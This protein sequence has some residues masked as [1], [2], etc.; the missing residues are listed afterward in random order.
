MSSVTNINPELILEAKNYVEYL[1]DNYLPEK[2]V[3][4]SKKHTIDVYN[5][6]NTIGSELSLSNK[7]IYIVEIAALF[8]DIG[9]IESNINH[10]EISTLYA[11]KFLSRKRVN[12]DIIKIVTKAIMS[13]K[14]PQNPKSLIDCIL[15]DAD[16]MYL[17]GENYCNESELLRKEWIN[18][19]KT[20]FNLE[21]FNKHSLE[22]FKSHYYHTQYG[23]AI[24]EPLKQQNFIKIKNKLI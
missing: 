18:M 14:M 13:T 8:H 23:K 1:F 17:S 6:V 15:C 9:Y 16:L 20:N 21:E 10:E 19:G 11:K 7:D 3:Y 24:L 5:N 2:Y 22:F 12:S 4:H